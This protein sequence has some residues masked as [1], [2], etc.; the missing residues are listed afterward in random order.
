MTPYALHMTSH[1]LFVTSYHFIYDVKSNISNITSTLCDLTSTVCV[2]APTLSLISQPPY[3]W[4]HIRYTCDILPSIYIS[5]NT[6]PGKNLYLV[7]EYILELLYDLDMFQGCK[8]E[9]TVSPL[10]KRSDS[11]GLRSPT[12]LPWCRQ[13]NEPSLSEFSAGLYVE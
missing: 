7:L 13:G 10:T 8:S 4:Y 9:W 5:H 6:Q 12:H 2:I 11:K 3:I 1:P